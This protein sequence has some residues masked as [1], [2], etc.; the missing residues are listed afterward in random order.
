M[1]VTQTKVI[2]LE[3]FMNHPL[4]LSGLGM[5]SDSGLFNVKIFDDAAG[6]QGDKTHQCVSSVVYDLSF[7]SLHCLSLRKRLKQSYS[8]FKR[9]QK[10]GLVKLFETLK[11]ENKL[12]ELL[13]S[14]LLILKE[15]YTFPIVHHHQILHFSM[16]YTSLLNNSFHS[17][18]IGKQLNAASAKEAGSSLQHQKK[19]SVTY[20]N[21][22]LENQ[23]LKVITQ[24]PTV[25]ESC[26]SLMTVADFVSFDPSIINKTLKSEEKYTLT[27]RPITKSELRE[28]ML[29]HEVPSQIV[30]ITRQFT[31]STPLDE[32]NDSIN[33]SYLFMDKS[34]AK[35]SEPTKTVFA[36]TSSTTIFSKHLCKFPLDY[37][38]SLL[39]DSVSISSLIPV[40]KF[41]AK[42]N[43]EETTQMFEQF[44]HTEKHV[45]ESDILNHQ[46]DAVV[47]YNESNHTH[48]A[49]YTHSNSLSARNSMGSS[50]IK[51]IDDSLQSFV[52]EDDEQQ[53]PDNTVL[54]AEKTADVSL[55]EESINDLNNRSKLTFEKY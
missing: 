47:V 35:I 41:S 13:A 50:E 24:Y 16:K 10:R 21:K 38:E 17:E 31:S 5:Y 26:D 19:Y 43:S 30:S 7:D 37:P 4:H 28:K 6:E 1:E 49:E 23:S 12:F 8:I 9:R 53:V 20:M 11:S 54:K 46:K 42:C 48:A 32:K 2:T 14:P 3:S 18:T 29:K 22:T 55:Y 34:Q 25:L 33:K 45:S 40:D 27:N 39:E 44:E 36:E 52:R 15:H 51:T